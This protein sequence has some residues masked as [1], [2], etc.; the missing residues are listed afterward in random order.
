MIKDRTQPGFER[1]LQ[2]PSVLMCHC[3]RWCKPCTEGVM[4]TRRREHRS[5]PAT[6][7]TL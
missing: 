6:V 4:R 2:G 7:I 3:R 1:S 5:T